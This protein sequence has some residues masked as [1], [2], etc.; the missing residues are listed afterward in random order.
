MSPFKC[1]W[2]RGAQR[3]APQQQTAAVPVVSSEPTVQQQFAA[4]AASADSML[5]AA[6][7]AEDTAVLAESETAAHQAQV[8]SCLEPVLAQ[9]LLQLLSLCALCLAAPASLL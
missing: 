7:P 8:G 9:L 3:P 6:Q 2:S 4:T 1:L 5:A